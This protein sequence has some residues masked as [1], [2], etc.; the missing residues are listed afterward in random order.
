MASKKVASKSFVASDTYTGPI[1]CTCSKGNH[2]VAGSS[3]PKKEAHSNVMSIIMADI[4]DEAAM[5][6]M[7]RKINLLMKVVE[8][9]DHEITA[10]R[11]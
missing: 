7:K 5:V 3:K 8:K 9:R 4:T 10:L 11:E 6:E 2:P 1:T